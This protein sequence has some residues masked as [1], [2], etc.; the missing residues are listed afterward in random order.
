MDARVNQSQLKILENTWANAIKS[1]KSVKVEIGISYDLTGR[2]TMFDVTYSIDGTVV[3]RLI[4][5]GD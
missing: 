3:N 1:G 4:A 2:P 5:N